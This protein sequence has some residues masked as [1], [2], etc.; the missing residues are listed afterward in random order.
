MSALL[1]SRDRTTGV[2]AAA[3]PAPRVAPPPETPVP[4]PAVLPRPRPAAV[5]G[6]VAG[7]AAGAAGTLARGRDRDRPGGRASH[8]TRAHRRSPSRVSPST[9]P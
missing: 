1:P 5:W 4:E 9:A 6:V 7:M 8:G 2:A 3:I